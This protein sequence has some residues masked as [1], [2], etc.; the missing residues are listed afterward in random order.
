MDTEDVEAVEASRA[1]AKQLIA[2]LRR[3]M[4]HDL[5][6]ENALVPSQSVRSSSKSDAVF[7]RMTAKHAS[8]TG[9]A[10]LY[11]LPSL[12]ISMQDWPAAISVSQR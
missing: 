5:L 8:H 11:A 10:E 4:L 9:L 2:E 3:Q 6:T 7:C 12:G 1:A